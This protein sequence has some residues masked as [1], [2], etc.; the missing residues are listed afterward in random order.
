MRDTSRTLRPWFGRPT[1]RISSPAATEPSERIRRYAPGRNA[2]VKR[3][4]KPII[5]HTDAE[6]PAGHAGFG[7]LE[8]RGPDLP[9][10]ADERPVHVEP[11]RGQVLAELR[12]RQRSAELA[13]PPPRI[14]D[15]IGVDGLVDASVR[16]PVSLIV[17]LEIHASGGNPTDDRRLPD[18]APNLAAVELEGTRP[19]D[20]DGEHSSLGT[21]HFP[22]LPAAGQPGGSCISYPDRTPEASPSALAF[23]ARG[24]TVSPCR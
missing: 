13:L 2:S 9:A 23:G 15:R 21:R 7:D 14:F 12:D 11:L 22:F 8:Q 19:P 10:L 4:T 18:G 1:T 5:V 17:A 6:P 3:R 24:Q 16:L 20:V